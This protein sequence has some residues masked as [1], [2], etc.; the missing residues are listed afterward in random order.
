MCDMGAIMGDIPPFETLASHIGELV[1][2]L[3]APFMNQLPANQFRK[4]VE[5]GKSA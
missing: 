5:D 4:A 2:V 1:V 3:A